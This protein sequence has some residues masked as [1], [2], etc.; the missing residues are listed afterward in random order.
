MLLLLIRAILLE[1]V[2]ITNQ[3]YSTYLMVNQ[4]IAKNNAVEQLQKAEMRE[5]KAQLASVHKQN[6]CALRFFAT[7]SLTN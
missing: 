5:L 7:Q 3:S 1:Y 4:I 6:F 2:P